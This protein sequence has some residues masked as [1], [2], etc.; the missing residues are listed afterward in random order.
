V[1]GR[2][3]RTALAAWAAAVT[4]TAAAA[5]AAAVAVPRVPLPW[6]VAAVIAAAPFF[7][8]AQYA[9]ERRR[10]YLREWLDRLIALE[11]AQDEYAALLRAREE[12]LAFWELIHEEIAST[13][14]WPTDG[15]PGGS[16]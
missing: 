8:W 4:V 2:A 5:V 10:G 9:R 11:E 13:G 1:N 15:R 7:A 16:W 6:P 14:G 3:R 12:R